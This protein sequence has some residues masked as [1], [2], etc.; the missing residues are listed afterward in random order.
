M[1]TFLL[2]EQ[3]PLCVP[4]SPSLYG[5]SESWPTETPA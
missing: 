5:L 3:N 2:E 1:A 4:G